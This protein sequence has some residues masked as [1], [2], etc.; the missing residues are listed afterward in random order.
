MHQTLMPN[1]FARWVKPP[2]LMKNGRKW[3]ICD[4]EGTFETLIIMTSIGGKRKI[5]RLGSHFH[6]RNI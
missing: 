3:H 2:F 5:I 1:N 4:L 6:I